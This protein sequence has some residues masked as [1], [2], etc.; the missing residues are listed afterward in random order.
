MKK[1]SAGEKQPCVTVTMTINPLNAH[2]HAHT[3]TH[4]HSCKPLLLS[5]PGGLVGNGLAQQGSNLMS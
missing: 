3:V 2:T 1:S 4:S 5:S